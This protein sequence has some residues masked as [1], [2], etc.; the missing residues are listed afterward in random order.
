MMSNPV[1]SG[2]LNPNCMAEAGAILVGGEARHEPSFTAKVAKGRKG[3]FALNLLGFLLVVSGVCTQ[4][5]LHRTV[6]KQE[7]RLLNASAYMSVMR[8]S[9]NRK[10]VSVFTQP[11]RVPSRPSR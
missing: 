2:N 8:N 3:T 9:M 1:C 5:T 6:L 4:H 11:L 10:L 7:V